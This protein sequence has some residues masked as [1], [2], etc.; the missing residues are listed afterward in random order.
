[1]VSYT[2]L[3]VVPSE[4]STERNSRRSAFPSALHYS[5]SKLLSLAPYK[6]VTRRAALVFTAQE[7]SVC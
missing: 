4:E 2:Q 6:G 7:K 3:M 1:M 5:S